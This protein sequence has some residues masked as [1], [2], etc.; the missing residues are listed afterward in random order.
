M[1]EIPTKHS[2]AKSA[3]LLGSD[4]CREKRRKE[5]EKKISTPLKKL[6]IFTILHT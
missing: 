4:N 5:V 2:A 1:P 6:P 3:G